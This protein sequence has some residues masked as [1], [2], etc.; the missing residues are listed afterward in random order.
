MPKS[1]AVRT[2]AS[3]TRGCCNK[4]G[5]RE[6]ASDRAKRLPRRKA[7]SKCRNF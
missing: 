7:F 1:A 4:R 2:E 3:T 5:A 6:S